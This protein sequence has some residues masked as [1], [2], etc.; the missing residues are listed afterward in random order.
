M[1]IHE[2]KNEIKLSGSWFLIFVVWFNV[3][4]RKMLK[5]MAD[6]WMDWIRT[7]ASGIEGNHCT[8]CAVKFAFRSRE[9]K[10]ILLSGIL[11]KLTV[12]KN[13]KHI[14]TSISEKRHFLPKHS[15]LNVLT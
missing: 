11:V 15:S 1:Q 12:Q 8:K 10:E 2:P 13:V 5:Q 9:K 7:G 14:A 3:M 4:G 6:G